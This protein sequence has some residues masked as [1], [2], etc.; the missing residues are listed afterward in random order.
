MPKL[1]SALTVPTETRFEITRDKDQVRLREIVE[2]QDTTSK[3]QQ[4]LETRVPLFIPNPNLAS[5]VN[6]AA[7]EAFAH[8]QTTAKAVKGSSTVNRHRQQMNEEIYWVLEKSTG[9]SLPHDPDA[10]YTWWR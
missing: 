7:L 9:Q 1:I 4:V 3:K 2:Q 6:A 10:W 5:L 8:A